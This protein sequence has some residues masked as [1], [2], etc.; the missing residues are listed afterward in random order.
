MDGALSA[1]HMDVP[2]VD[3]NGR[4]PIPEDFEKWR[5]PPEGLQSSKKA[6]ASVWAC[7]NEGRRQGK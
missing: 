3:N 5:Q 4:D 1:V 2:I 7:P 6:F